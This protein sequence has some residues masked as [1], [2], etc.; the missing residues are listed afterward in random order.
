LG[1]QRYSALNETADVSY[2]WEGGGVKILHLELPLTKAEYLLHYATATGE[3]GDKRK[4]WYDIL[5][6]RSPE[7]L[8]ATLLKAV[9][10]DKLEADVPNASGNLY[11]MVITLTTPA[12]SL[13]RI[14]T[15][16][17]VRFGEDVARFVTAYPEQRKE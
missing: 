2:E 3:A 5:G 1:L 10:I 6:F 13:R 16:W 14:R 15:V 8:R 4:F 17:I 12:G 9:T 7:T 11:R